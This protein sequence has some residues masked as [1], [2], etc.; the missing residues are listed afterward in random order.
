MPICDTSWLL[1]LIH[2]EDA[3][4]AE[5]RR[6]AETPGR[7]IIPGVV[8]SEFAAALAG[9]IRRTSPTLDAPHEARNRVREFET[10][11]AFEIEPSYPVALAH[12]AYFEYPSLS[13]ADAVGVATALAI[14][15]ELLTFDEKQNAALKR[16]RRSRQR[17]AKE[18]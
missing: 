17:P 15:Q 10:N 8:L 13:Y 5:A 14:G 12:Q 4:H 11:A 6:D 7:Y 18:P 1:A 3:H 9:R 16:L 2:A